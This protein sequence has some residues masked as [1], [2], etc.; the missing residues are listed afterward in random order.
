MSED[1]LTVEQALAMLPD[2][3]E[4]HTFRQPAVSV[5]VGADWERDEL[6]EAIRSADRRVL[7]GEMATG[8]GH[9]MAIWS[10]GWLFIETRPAEP[11]TAVSEGAK[12]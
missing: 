3:D 7:T 11:Q 6:A 8:M 9:G 5:M 2:G 1:D 10:G 4:I 12:P